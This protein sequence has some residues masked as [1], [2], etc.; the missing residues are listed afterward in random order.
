MF[1]GVLIPLRCIY[2]D[3]PGLDLYE[4]LAY[5]ANMPMKVL[6]IGKAILANVIE[7]HRD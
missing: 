5:L 1:Y 4:A 7:E 2:L 6:A 3:Q